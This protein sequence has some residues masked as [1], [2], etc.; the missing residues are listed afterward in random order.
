MADI[1]DFRKR[2]K[3]DRTVMCGV[4]HRAYRQPQRYTDAGNLREGTCG[5]RSRD[6]ASQIYAYAA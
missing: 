1:N 4:A 6:R 5:Q 2:E 3:L